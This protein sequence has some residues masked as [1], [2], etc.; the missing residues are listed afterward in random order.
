MK[1][2]LLPPLAAWLRLSAALLLVLCA[3]NASALAS[4]VAV[5]DGE[6]FSLAGYMDYLPD[7]PDVAPEALLAGAYDS[8]LQRYDEKAV[9]FRNKATWFRLRVVNN[10]ADNALVLS[11]HDVLFTSVQ[12]LYNRAADNQPADRVSMTGG[13]L[14][15]PQEQPWPYYDIGFRLDIPPGQMR[16]VYLRLYTPYL[17]MLAPELSDQ[18][19]YNLNQR[20]KDAL[21]HLLV[22][23]MLGVMLYLAMLGIYVRNLREVRYCIGFVC[24]SFLILLYLRG[25]LFHL[26]P[27]N[28]WFNLRLYPL[29]FTAQAFAYIAFSRQHFKTSSD[30]P[31]VDR[32]LEA[33]QYLAGALLLASMALP[34]DWSVN[35]VLVMVFLLVALLCVCSVYV[36]ANS[37]RK[38]TIYIIGTLIFLFA[39]IMIAVESAGFIDLGGHSRKAYEAGICLQT[40]LFALALAE[41]ISDYQED[42]TR[43]AISAAEA[44]AENRAKSSFLAKMSHELRTPMNGLLGMLQ[45]LERT[46]LNDQQQHYLDVMRNSGRLLLGVIDDVLDYSRIVAGKLRIEE[47]DYSVVEVL[48][49]VEAM[50]TPAA[51]Q[52]MLHLHFS[53]NSSNPVL[54]HGDATRLRQIL[55]NLVGNAIKFTEQGT[56]TVR[57][58]VEQPETGAW[59]LHG[60]VEDTGIGMNNQL[61]AQLF[62]EYSQAD[63]IKSYGGSGLGLVICKQ[64]VEMMGGSILVESAPGYGSLFRFHI[65]VKAPT[66]G[67]TTDYSNT[68]RPEDG[69]R[70]GGRILI[71]ED[72]ETNREVVVGMLKQLGYVAHCVGNGSEAVRAICRPDSH[73]DAVL[74]DVEMPIL[75]GL[76]ATQQIRRWEAEQYRDATPIIALTAHAMRG[77]EEK[78]RHAGMDD[79]LSKP[80]D[81]VTLQNM[82]AKWLP[83]GTG[84]E[85]NGLE[86]NDLA[87][88]TQE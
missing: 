43:L 85:N 86:N 65:A 2:R 30:F 24:V 35:A 28:L 26:L 39:C 48:A 72:N 25:Y 44:H 29:L 47:Q 79:H 71:A 67:N 15:E 5:I 70:R 84:L 73:W 7:N 13:L 42:Q 33:G 74:M 68:R 52:K 27:Q 21:G 34:I 76:S 6:R 63:G 40:I 82:L 83:A 32:L 51:R 87:N 22:G 23:V 45:L 38:L 14:D 62:R 1:T 56:V 75:D 8:Q 9:K 80:V 59:L 60:D 12:L 3:H 16:T 46:P 78:T 58:W 88:P 4:P 37:Q 50:F 36:W 20:A 55:I 10:T 49:D 18:Q 19:S 11:M 41:K 53:I 77:H 69:P 31:H 66:G 64:L 81:L 17:M 57:M 61:L 54:V